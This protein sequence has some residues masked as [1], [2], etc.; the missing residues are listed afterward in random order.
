[1]NSK[2]IPLNTL[3]KIVEAERKFRKE[4]GIKIRWKRM[5][6]GSLINGS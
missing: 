3:K 6:V 1:M 4:R 5:K 2:K